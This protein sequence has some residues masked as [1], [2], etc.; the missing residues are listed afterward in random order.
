MPPLG[1]QKAPQ[2]LI[3]DDD[4]AL[5]TALGRWVDKQGWTYIESAH[6]NDAINILAS[7]K[8]DLALIDVRLPDIDGLELS[9]HIVNL[10]TDIPILLMTAFADLDTARQALNIG[11]YEYFAKPL[12]FKD[13]RVGIERALQHRKLAQENRAHRIKLEQEVA[14][15]TKELTQT[16]AQLQSEIEERKQMERQLVQ[17]E[18]LGA[19]AEMSEGISHNLNNIL[20]GILGPAQ[21]IELQTQDKKILTEA[22]VIQE[23]ALRAADL[24]KR[25][26]VSVRGEK[27]EFHAIDVELTIQEAIKTAQPRWKDEAEAKG[28]QIE[29][30]THLQ[31]TP[32][33]CSTTAGLHNVLLNLIFNAVDAMPTDGRITI[34]TET[35]DEHVQVTVSDTGQGMNEETMR[36]VFEPFFT[37]QAEVGRG[38]GMAG[39]YASITRWGGHINLESTPNK[40]T[41]AT[42][43]LPIWTQRHAETDQ[44][45]ARTTRMGKILIVED[46][47]IVRSFL[48]RALSPHH[49]VD[50][51]SNGTEGLALFA[52]KTYDVVLV[53]LGM[54]NLPGDQVIA[55]MRQIAP[56]VSTIL[57]TGWQ[58]SPKDPRYQ[59]FDFHLQ[60]PFESVQKITTLVAQAIQAYDNKQKNP[61]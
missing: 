6:A 52:Q 47:N 21:L 20:T 26:A 41:T 4:H 25:L 57:I 61:Q 3:V 51:V 42:V 14:Q 8:V 35:T 28:I 39:V 18:R 44:D 56:N 11:V 50:A 33:V 55:Q 58:L 43:H 37:T 1:T 36:R 13:L 5:R 60:K 9:Q 53:D 31:T 16:N 29:M 30:E 2:I 32:K 49:Q 40:G 38:L 34:S 22:R 45:L 46:E 7:Q 54:P 10:D 15:R 23:A 19:L 12:D 27:E 48:T 17:F 24:V 59:A